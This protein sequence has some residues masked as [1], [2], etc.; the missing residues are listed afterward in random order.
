MIELHAKTAKRR[1]AFDRGRRMADRAHHILVVGELLH[2]TTGARH[3]ARH[4]RRHETDLPLMA[5]QTR[6]A[7]VL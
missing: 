1:K 5:Q 7:S 3:M 2:V 6:H 4:L